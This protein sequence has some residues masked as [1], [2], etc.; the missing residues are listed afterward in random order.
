MGQLIIKAKKCIL[1]LEESEL[2]KCLAAK[3]DIFQAAIRRGKGFQRAE[4]VR[5]W[6]E[7]QLTAND[8]K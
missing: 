3:P 6:Q 8:E 7:K 1:V 4:K 5:K 2:M